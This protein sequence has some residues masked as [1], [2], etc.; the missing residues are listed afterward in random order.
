[1]PKKKMSYPHWDK[2]RAPY[3]AEVRALLAEGKT[4]RETKTRLTLNKMLFAEITT[5]RAECKAVDKNFS[6]S[7]ASYLVHFR[8]AQQALERIRGIMGDLNQEHGRVIMFENDSPHPD[9]LPQEF[10]PV[11]TDEDTE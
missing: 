2:L 8:A 7:D 3:N 9:G 6:I 5:F 11:S 4:W 1:M 10:E